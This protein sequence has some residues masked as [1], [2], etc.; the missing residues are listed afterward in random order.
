MTLASTE[1]IRRFLLH[2]LPAR[3]HRIRYYGWL[4]NRH[5]KEQLARCRHL[6]SGDSRDAALDGLSRPIPSP[7]GDLLAG[8]PGLGRAHAHR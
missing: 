8:L 2:V 1:F 4:G 3:F 5:R 7:H 6:G